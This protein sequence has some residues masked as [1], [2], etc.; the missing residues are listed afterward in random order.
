[1]KPQRTTEDPE[2][3]SIPTEFRENYRFL[4][5]L[6]DCKEKNNSFKRGL[7]ALIERN[8]PYLTAQ[9][10]NRRQMKLVKGFLK[11]LKHKNP[12]CF[13]PPVPAELEASLRIRDKSTWL[14][15]E[16]E[17]IQKIELWR[18]DISCIRRYLARNCRMPN[19]QPTATRVTQRHP[20]AP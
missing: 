13:S 6:I 14:P 8:A 19:A 2:L 20:G 1:M 11:G 9:R 18:G 5:E 12:D 3:Q 4:S 7:R 15:W 10:L 16:A 17:A